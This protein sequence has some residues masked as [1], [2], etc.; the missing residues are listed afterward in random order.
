[1][2]KVEKMENQITRRAAT[3]NDTEFARR[4]HHAAYH[5]VIV[6]QFG[7]FDEK[8][9]DEFFAKGWNPET[10][11]VLL[12]GN[13]EVGYCSIERFPDHILAHEL[14]LSPEFQGRGIGSKILGEL[15]DEARAK[16]IPIKLQVLKENREQYLYRKLGF[17]DAGS[18]DTHIEM[19]FNPDK[20]E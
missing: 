17:K 20:E 2:E 15:L 16:H 4:T 3:E 5:D 14:V 12:R 13:S 19:E 10:H 6:R 8:A 18:T 7:S 11:E 1:M 9:Q